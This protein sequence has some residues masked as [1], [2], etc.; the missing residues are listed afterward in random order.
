MKAL[1]IVISSVRKVIELCGRT[2]GTVP[3][4]ARHDRDPKNPD[5]RVRFDRC[6]MGPAWPV[7]D[8]R[9]INL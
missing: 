1:L 4:E 6:L 2:A 5:A 9:V 8:L 3:R 7:A